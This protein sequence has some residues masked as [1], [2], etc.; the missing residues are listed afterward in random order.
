MNRT[1]RFFKNALLLQFPFIILFG[2]WLYSRFQIVEALTI[3]AIHPHEVNFIITSPLLF[4]VI[5]CLISGIYILLKNNDVEEIEEQKKLRIHNFWKFSF[6]SNILLLILIL[7]FTLLA[8]MQ[9]EGPFLFDSRRII[10]I[11]AFLQALFVPLLSLIIASFLLSSGIYWKTN[12]SLALV[13]IVLSLF[14][15]FSWTLSE[16]VIIDEFRGM[17]ENLNYGRDY[18]E[19]PENTVV[20]VEPEESEYQEGESMEDIQEA[21]ELE[22]SWNYFINNRYDLKGGD[23]FT[24]V[25]FPMCDNFLLNSEDDEVYFLTNY[26]KEIRRSPEAIS[27]AFEMY[28]SVLYSSVSRRTYRISNIDKTIDALLFTY[29]DLESSE[30]AGNKE[31]I[32]KIMTA[33]REGYDLDAGD[34]YPELEKYFT[35]ETIDLL[36]SIRLSNGSQYSN[37]DIVWFYS[38][39]ARR[40]HEN[41]SEE[42]VAVLREIKENYN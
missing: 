30:S 7:L 23:R 32:Y 27:L 8:N 15:L 29:E 10:H 5:G 19:V 33:E 24:E 12:R 38:F 17:S 28:K 37:G 6:Y 42:V 36:E 25:R 11:F 4:F 26:V 21:T 3:P 40:D 34:Y 16:F 39:W 35:P 31:K 14:F 20:E 22:K 41:N 2:I 18:E 1:T 13:T 9:L